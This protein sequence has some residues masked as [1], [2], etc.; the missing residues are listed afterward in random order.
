LQAAVICAPSL[1]ERMRQPIFY[2][3]DDV[4]RHTP[5]VSLP[6]SSGCFTD[7]GVS[8]VGGTSSTRS[9][10]ESTFPMSSCETDAHTTSPSS[11]TYDQVKSPMLQRARWLPLRS[12]WNLT[13]LHCLTKGVDIGE[14]KVFRNCRRILIL[15]WFASISQLFDSMGLEYWEFVARIWPV[16]RTTA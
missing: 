15:V 5:F 11:P 12:Q 6:T 8:G 4:S 9:E 14:V 1:Q 10:P 7:V 3:S 13:N 2:P 16:H